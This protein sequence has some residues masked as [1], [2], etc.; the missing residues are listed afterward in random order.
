[1]FLPSIHYFRG[2]AIVTIVIG[3]CYKIVGFP[4]AYSL[5]FSLNGLALIFSI[6]E[7]TLA[8]LLSGGTALFVFISGF[9]F[10]H[11]FYKRFRYVPFMQKKV[12]NVFLPY[13]IL[14]IPILLINC[15]GLLRRHNELSELGTIKLLV[16]STIHWLTVGTH[17]TAYWYIPFA[18]VLFLASPIFMLFIK[19][20]D[21]VKLLLIIVLTVISMLIHRPQGNAN[22]LQS[23]IYF[24]PIYLFGI[25]TSIKRDYLYKVF[26][27]KD[28]WLLGLAVLFALVQAIIYEK[29]GNLHKL[30]ALDFAGFD[31]SLI[32]KIVLCL[33]GM[34]S[35]HRLEEKP[36]IKPLD[37]LAKYSFSIFFFHGYAFVF[38][39]AIDMEYLPLHSSIYSAILVGFVITL[40]CLGIA[41]LIKITVPK[42]SRILIG[43]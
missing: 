37:V 42:Y 8:S 3:H 43:A 27:K 17:L 35:L 29:T 24:T 40:V 6:V 12:I 34:I 13:L 33:F 11:V 25:Y 15:R 4:Q 5:D 36:L 22:V 19:L 26:H 38:F 32:Q 16:V 9:M 31:I 1:M 14:S 28:L 39:K 23:F 41:H 2:I 21:R 30:E 18:M 20:P 7:K 10:H